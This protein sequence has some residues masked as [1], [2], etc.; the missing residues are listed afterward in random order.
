MPQP[1]KLLDQAVAADVVAV[2][3]G[4]GDEG[5]MREVRA[6]IGDQ[7]AGAIEVVH[8][9]RVDEY[10]AVRLVDEVI[11]EAWA[12]SETGFFTGVADGGLLTGV[13]DR[14]L[15]AG[16]ADGGLFA[17]IPDRGLL[18]GVRDR[19]LLAGIAD[20]RFLV[21]VRGPGSQVNPI[22]RKACWPGVFR[23]RPGNSRKSGRDRNGQ[24]KHHD[25]DEYR[26]GR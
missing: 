8:A 17:R 24:T 26:T 10:R 2:G 21:E 20:G 7:P 19:R 13:P 18:A 25:A 6:R 22:R 15:L 16:V 1:R 14:G 11:T 9:G 4:V 23:G 12:G 5:G 3:V